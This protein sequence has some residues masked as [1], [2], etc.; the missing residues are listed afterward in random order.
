M[1]TMFTTFTSRH[2]VYALRAESGTRVRSIARTRFAR[3][4]AVLRSRK[5]G[6][7]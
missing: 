5:G 1:F 3:G 2:T 4:S 7:G 6:A